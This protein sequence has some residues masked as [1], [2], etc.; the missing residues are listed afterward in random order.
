MH[1]FPICNHQNVPKVS[2]HSASLSR[3]LL[4]IMQSAFHLYPPAAQKYTFLNCSHNSVPH[5]HCSPSDTHKHVCAHT[6]IHEWNPGKEADHHDN[7]VSC[8]LHS[9]RV[10]WC[11]AARLREEYLCG[12]TGVR[13]ETL[14]GCCTTGAA[15]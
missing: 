2:K 3:S 5:A 12:R 8:A 13:I 7:R 6:H 4:F 11:S 1:I 14:S 15:R 9:L 10:R